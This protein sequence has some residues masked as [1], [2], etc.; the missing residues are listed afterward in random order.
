MKRAIN[1]FKTKKDYNKS[2]SKLPIISLSYIEEIDKC[3]RIVKNDF[4]QYVTFIAEEANSTIGLESLSS[5]QI[6]EYS[7][8]ASTWTNMDTS[9]TI[10]LSNIDDE[11]GMSFKYKKFKTLGFN[12]SDFN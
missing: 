6:L 8:D 2:F 7:T 4:S 5:N 11:A 3:K 10:M 1:L 12:K 9:T